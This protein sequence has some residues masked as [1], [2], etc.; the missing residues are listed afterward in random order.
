MR[1]D[2]SADFS[3][4]TGLRT[5]LQQ[6]LETWKNSLDL[7]VLDIEK[8]VVRILLWGPGKYSTQHYEKRMQILAHLGGMATS[9]EV[10]TSEM[11][12]DENPK[13]VAAL[14]KLRDREELHALSAD[15]IFVLL[16]SERQVTG[17]DAEV[18]SLAWDPRIQNRMW[19][20]MPKGWNKSG[21]LES[22]VK[23]FP[24]ERKRY[25]TFNQIKDC[26][27]IRSLCEEK[28]RQMRGQKYMDNLRLRRLLGR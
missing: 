24:D 3:Q 21:F 9:N 20:F 11:L 8:T 4:R 5:E 16:V 7:T 23:E 17:P 2:S 6:E 13:L 12:D 19:L 14:P 10:K 26:H 27:R 25:Y 28:V 15:L 18:L 22:G 1:T